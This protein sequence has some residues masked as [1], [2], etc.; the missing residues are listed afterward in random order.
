MSDRVREGE[1]GCGQV[2][3]RVTGEPI[4]VNNC[5]CRQCQQQTGGTSVV[6]AFYEDERLEILEGHLT[7][8]VV[9]AGSG[10]PHTI[11]R[12]DNCGVAL[13]SYYPRLGRLGVGIRVGT[14]DEKD[15]LTPVAAIFVSEK[16]PWVTLPEGLPHFDKTYD[17]RELLDA[18]KI[19]RM[20]GMIERRKAGG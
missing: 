7:E 9:T 17:Y 18:D 4:F 3:Y 14:M 6:N 1:C 15:S 8:H 16:M 5:H 12:C 2:R 13:W 11:C 20:D 10:G 19:A